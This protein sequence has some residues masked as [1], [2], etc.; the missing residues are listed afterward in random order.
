MNTIRSFSGWILF[1]IMAV[2]A[3]FFWYQSDTRGKYIEELNVRIVEINAQVNRL[4]AEMAAISE[5]IDNTHSGT[6]TRQP[7]TSVDY[8]VHADPKLDTAT[9]AP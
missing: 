3:A 9:S 1:L 6:P 5:K 2:I 8:T 4:T 7:G